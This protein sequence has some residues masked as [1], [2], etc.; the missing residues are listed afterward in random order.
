MEEATSTELQA[1]DIENSSQHSIISRFNQLG[2][3]TQLQIDE[4]EEI[5][6]EIGQ[7]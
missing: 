1:R 4:L 6:K 5:M 7:L 3:N 2:D